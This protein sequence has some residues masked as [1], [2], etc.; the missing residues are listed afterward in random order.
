MAEKRDRGKPPAEEG[1]AGRARLNAQASGQGRVYQAGRD[2]VFHYGQ[3]TRSRT[4]S[5]GGEDAECP[6]PGLASFGR[7]QARWF[8]GREA[9]TSDLVDAMDRRLCTGGVQIVIGPSGAGKSSLLRA[10]LLARLAHGALPESASWRQVLLTP[11]ATAPDAL[12]AALGPDADAAVRTIVV[13]DQFEE[14]FTL[15]PDEGE[16]QVFI[17][18][19]TRLAAASDGS[20]PRL[21]VVGL[22]ADFYAACLEYPQ[23]AEPIDRALVVT[24]MTAE[25]LR[26][27]IVYPAQDVDLEIEPGLVEILLRDLGAEGGGRG[28]YLAGRL[29][30]LAYALRRSWQVRHG[31]TLTVEGYES[32]GGIESAIADTAERVYRGL[33]EDGRVIARALFLRLVRV[34]ENTEDSRRRLSRDDLVGTGLDQR[35][36][37]AVIDA[38]TR[39]RLL[40][41]EQDEHRDDVEITHEVLIH[42]WPTLHEW[43]E[44]DRAELLV[45]QRL[46][47]DAATWRASGED[48]AYLY[49]DSRLAAATELERGPKG[50]ELTS[51]EHGFVAASA[52]RARR[53]TRVVREVI[54]TLTVLFLLAAG[55]GVLAVLQNGQVTRQRDAAI[56][57]QAAD[58]SEKINDSS[59]AAQ[60]GLAAYRIAPTPEA[61]GALLSM[62]S[63]S[64]GARLLGHTGPVELVAFRRDGRVLASASSDATARLWDVSDPAHPKNLGVLKGHTGSVI[65]VAFGPDG[66]TV[67]TASNDATTRLWDVTDPAAPRT[68]AS[69]KGHRERVRSVAFAPAG[70]L[71]ATASDDGKVGIWNIADR[72]RPRLLAKVTAVTG[73]PAVRFSPDSRTMAVSSRG[74]RAELWDVSIPKHPKSRAVLNGHTSS[75]T[76]VAFSPDGRVLATASE[77]TT[78]GLWDV[79]A[80]GHERR[81]G[82]VRG[83]TALVYDATFSPDGRTLATASADTTARLWNVTDL[84]APRPLS[85]MTG[86]ANSVTGVAF[87][88]DGRVLATS[89]ADGTVRA[90]D[91]SSP[92]HV[93][94]RALLTTSASYVTKVAY[95]PDG[96]LLASAGSDGTAT[97]WDATDPARALS[98]ATLK[99]HRKD[100]SGIVFAP[101]GRHLATSS[102]DS[103]AVLWDIADPAHPVVLSRLRGHA[104]AVQSVTFGPDGRLVATTGRDGWTILWDVSRPRHPQEVSR[105]GPPDNW[106]NITAFAPDGRTIVVGSGTG[107][108]IVW[109]IADVAE[110][111]RLAVV[112]AHNN[113]LTDAKFDHEGRLLATSSNDGTTRL[114]DLVRPARP[115][116]VATLRGH[117]N[118]VAGVDFNPDGR[119][120]ATASLDSSV[121]LWDIAKPSDPA[122]RAV[123][124]TGTAYANDVRFSPKGDTLATADGYGRV[125]LSGLD[126]AK[127]ENYVCARAGM[128]I[129]RAE[130]AQYIPDLSYAP[131]C[132]T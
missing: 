80:A 48:A 122:L 88:P 19:L 10:G 103:T 11:T 83:H 29:P 95:A 20:P 73:F 44:T 49:T 66:R 85:S 113:S 126:V 61:R 39:E 51:T 14:L 37:D 131:P 59:L 107:A 70:A 9:L 7:D 132:G 120:L 117:S 56:S 27:A 25:Q 102:W 86:F 15:C 74:G 34:G 16:R 121:R 2:Q 35:A 21:V 62:L 89:S 22:R 87:R 55:A 46:A 79:S 81:L 8:C 17:D 72:A 68:L 23:L 128:P 77:D 94:D 33:D 64:V 47:E 26:E 53:R 5:E 96:R 69:M 114:W 93:A 82:T 42:S 32:T 12:D 28:G 43:I 101:D 106:I 4:Y 111:K 65:G 50:A 115:S 52:Y 30:Y 112:R 109:D 108:V 90:W 24:A 124:S 57:R 97:L 100:I 125:V 110:P 3:R 45:R 71:L 127:A 54:A 40:T 76:S 104:N 1:P 6:Y 105:L 63:R 129:T 118:V 78:I 91:V 18:R 130:W 13:V 31:S 58:A 67:A 84:R 99:G 36:A 116:P 60:L 75:L 92:A 119:L 41:R 98:L 38:F 123:I